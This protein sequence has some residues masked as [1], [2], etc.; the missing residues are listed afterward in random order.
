[1]FEIQFVKR[2]LNLFQLFILKKNSY[3]LMVIQVIMCD[4]KNVRNNL[5]FGLVESRNLR[6]IPVPFQQKRVLRY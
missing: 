2:P 3:I 5:G 1:M 4:V 6:Y